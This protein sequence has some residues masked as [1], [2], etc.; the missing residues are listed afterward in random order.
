MIDPATAR[1]WTGQFNIIDGDVREEGPNIAAFQGR[2]VEGDVPT[3]YLLAEPASS[4]GEAVVGVM[5]QAIGQLY[6]QQ[7]V[8]LTGNVLRALRGAHDSLYQWNQQNER[9]S[10]SAAGCSSAAVR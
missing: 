7:D 10:W 8:S 9:G 1:I 5:V 6:R 3:L 4:E 2:G